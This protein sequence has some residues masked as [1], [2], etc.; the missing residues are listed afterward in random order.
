MTALILVIGFG[1]G[2]KDFQMANL[3]HVGGL[4]TGIALA[5][6]MSDRRFDRRS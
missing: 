3:A 2:T 6:V 4:A 5:F 1:G